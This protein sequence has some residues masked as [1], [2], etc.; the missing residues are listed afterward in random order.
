MAGRRAHS[1]KRP[2]EEL[3]R[4]ACSTDPIEPET[5]P[6][7]LAIAPRAAIATGVA[8]IALALLLALRAVALAPSAPAPSPLPT[9]APTDAAAASPAQTAPPGAA[10]AP[11]PAGPA[12]TSGAG[13]PGGGTAPADPLS[14]AAPGQDRV[15]VHVAGAVQSPGVVLLRHGARVVDAIEAAGGATA[16]ADTDQLNLAR[17]LADGEQVRVPRLGETL[18][19]QDPGQ[20]PAH[21]GGP[22]APG[23]PG[24]QTPGD[25]AGTDPQAAPGSRININTATAS[26]LEGLPGIGPAL[27]QRIVEHRQTHGPF[28]SVE[29]L[30]DVPGIGQAKLEALKEAAT[31]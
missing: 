28:A 22:A 26:Q 17:V 9:P 10:G 30:T 7:R 13:A 12:A 11:Q 25:A 18:P 20:D 31:V 23:A 24:P 4:L 2:L 14:T 5:H 19:P 21:A 15:V 27:A 16:E 8:L 1:G 29:D 3:V 6:R